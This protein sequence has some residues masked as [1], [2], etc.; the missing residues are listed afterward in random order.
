MFGP[1]LTEKITEGVLGDNGLFA[2]DW[3]SRATVLSASRFSSTAVAP[4]SVPRRR[5]CLGYPVK[6][7]SGPNGYVTAVPAEQVQLWLDF[8]SYRVAS[9]NG[10]VI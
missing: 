7:L 8:L 1:D 2:Y 6:V 4:F 3:K 5:F 9:V 10:R